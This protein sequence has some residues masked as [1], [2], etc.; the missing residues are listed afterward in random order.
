MLDVVIN[1]IRLSDDNIYAQLKRIVQM[2]E[3]GQAEG[4]VDRVGILT[5]ARRDVW[6]IARRL[7]SE[8]IHII[9]ILR[10][11]H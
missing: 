9:N 7:L 2:A 5:G 11:K 10:S 3:E 6:S 4:H 8:G 1:S